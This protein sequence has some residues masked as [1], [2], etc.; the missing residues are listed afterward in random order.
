MIII[1]GGR[2]WIKRMLG[3]KVKER[4]RIFRNSDIGR[5]VVQSELRVKLS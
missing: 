4:K 2:G 1:T 3:R 5:C